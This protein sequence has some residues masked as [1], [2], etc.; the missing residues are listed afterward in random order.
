MLDKKLEKLIKESF[1]DIAL[2]INELDYEDRNSLLAE[3]F[4]WIHKDLNSIE[5]LMLPYEAYTDRVKKE[6]KE[7]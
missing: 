7:D 6:F 2:R 3:Y 5:I 1:K 4:E